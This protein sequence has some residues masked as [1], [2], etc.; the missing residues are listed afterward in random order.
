[1]TPGEAAAVAMFLVPLVALL[2][3]KCLAKPLERLVQ[4]KMKDSRIKA[5]LLK[6]RQQ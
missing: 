2:I 5:I 1:M 6:E 3:R 4:R